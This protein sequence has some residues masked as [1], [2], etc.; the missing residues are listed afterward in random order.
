MVSLAINFTG[1]REQTR[2][3]TI[4]I[5]VNSIVAQQSHVAACDA[6]RKALIQIE[7]QTRHVL[8]DY[9]YFKIKVLQT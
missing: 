5:H 2:G 1:M 8:P 3:E 4:I 6:V 9:S 7:G